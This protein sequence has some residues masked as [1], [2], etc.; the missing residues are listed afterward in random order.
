M[1]GEQFFLGV[2]TPAEVALIIDFS[3]L[4]CAQHGIIIDLATT[5]MCM[6]KLH[7]DL[8]TSDNKDLV[9]HICLLWLITINM[10]DIH[11]FHWRVLPY[12]QL[13]KIF[14]L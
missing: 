4:A 2:C 7:M 10:V 6:I 8:I 14:Q 12:S 9:E 13:Y 1:G 5:S 11:F 3:A